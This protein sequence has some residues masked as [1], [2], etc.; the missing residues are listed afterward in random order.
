MGSTLLQLKDPRKADTRILPDTFIYVCSRNPIAIWAINYL[1]AHSSS[2]RQVVTFFATP[3]PIS[4][5][6][7]HVLLFDTASV[8]EWP[9]LVPR[10]TAAQYKAILLVG[11]RWGSGGAMH[12]ALGLGVSGIVHVATEL[13]T[14]IGKAIRVVASGQVWVS[15]T[16]NDHQRDSQR[17]NCSYGPH[18]SFREKQVLDLITL[19]FSNRKIGSVL[20]ISERTAKFHV[21][22]V[23]YKLGLRRRGEIR[24]INRDSTIGIQTGT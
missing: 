8:P 1:L 16:V 14:Q 10:W 24:A 11:E 18:F 19:G 9:E 4:S 2:N 20:G 3:L 17:E 12:R 23:L 22:N 6:G 5:N 13:A 15:K 21:H 7:M